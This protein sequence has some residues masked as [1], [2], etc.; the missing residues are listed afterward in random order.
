MLLDDLWWRGDCLAV[1]NDK[2]FRLQLMNEF[3]DAPYAGHLGI[4]K[5]KENI[6]RYFWWPNWSAEVHAY[7]QTCNEARVLL[8]SLGVY[9][10]SNHVPGEK[11]R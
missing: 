3:H 2:A 5:T 9:G 4:T 6:G 11:L 7:I 8:A 1:P 10:A